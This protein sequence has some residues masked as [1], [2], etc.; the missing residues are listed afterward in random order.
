MIRVIPLAPSQIGQAVSVERSCLETAW[1]ESQL[2]NLPPDSVYLVAENEE[3]TVCGICSARLLD[4]EAELLNLAVLP[5]FRRMH[6][7]SELMTALFSLAIENGC[8]R[9][10]LEVAKT[11]EPA[12]ALY[13]EAGFREIGVRRGF[14]RGV[15]AWTMEK[16][17]C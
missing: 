4:G 11:N 5:A 9:M 6:I 16:A 17:L 10:Y 2:S 3:G 1:T 15:D 13:R 12:I 7:A 8:G 14:Y